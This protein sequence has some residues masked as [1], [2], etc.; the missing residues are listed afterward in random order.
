M[1]ATITEG[2]ARWRNGEDG[3]RRLSLNCRFV[4]KSNEPPEWRQGRPRLVGVGGQGRNARLWLKS[5]YGPKT[6]TRP[7]A[8]RS[9]PRGGH[10]RT[11]RN[12]LIR[13]SPSSLFHTK[14]RRVCL[15]NGS[16]REDGLQYDRCQAE[17]AGKGERV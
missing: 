9:K 15:K 8:R 16:A 5:R 3:N 13:Q 17:I 2:V 10:L 12:V 11:V 6:G 1:W 7:A 14:G 4:A